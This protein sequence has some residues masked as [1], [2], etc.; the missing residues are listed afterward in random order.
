MTELVT[1][2]GTVA[3]IEEMADNGRRTVDEFL[4]RCQRGYGCTETFASWMFRGRPDLVSMELEY[5][6]KDK[7]KGRVLSTVQFTKA[8]WRR[9]SLRIPGIE[10]PQVVM[11]GIKGRRIGDVVEGSPFPDFIIN[12]AV[13]DRHK[14]TGSVTLRIRCDGETLARIPRS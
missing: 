3:L 1:D 7:R 14:A 4:D 9:G 5:D 11:L 13:H 2:L 12:H 10:L 8:L 6:P